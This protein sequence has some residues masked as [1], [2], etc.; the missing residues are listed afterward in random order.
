MKELI[1]QNK[2]LLERIKQLEEKLLW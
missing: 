2:E 1:K